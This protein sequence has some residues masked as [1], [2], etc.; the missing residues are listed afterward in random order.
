VSDTLTKH[1]DIE[2]RRLLLAARQARLF[3]QRGNRGAE[4]ETQ[5]VQWLRGLVEPEYTVS[6]GEVMDSFGTELPA[7]DRAERHQLDAIVHQN[8]RHARRLTLPSG[9]RLVPIE[10]VAAVVE[11]KL[12]V[13]HS[14]F[15]LTDAAAAHTGK[16]RL[17]VSRG[18][19]FGQQLRLKTL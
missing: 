3:D 4:V 5:V 9:L 19:W 17:S 7:L 12:E 2:R 10:T 6:T 14:K 1:M 8:T 15:K 13:D 16:L 11:V 18:R